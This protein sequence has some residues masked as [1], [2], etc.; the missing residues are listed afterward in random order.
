M[1]RSSF[2]CIRIKI[3]MPS[4]VKKQEIK[5]YNAPTFVI[6]GEKDI[7]FPGK[8]VI[9]RAKVIFPDLKTHLMSG[10]GHMNKLSS[11]KNKFLMKM[12][13]EFFGL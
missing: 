10:C 12:I 5:G 8:K 3:G 9:E 6:A 13:D 2:E 4:N 11:D 7:L 1:V